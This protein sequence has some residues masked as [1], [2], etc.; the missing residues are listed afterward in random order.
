MKAFISG[1]LFFLSINFVFGQKGL[2]YASSFYGQGAFTHIKDFHRYTKRGRADGSFKNGAS[3]GMGTNYFKEDGP[4]FSFLLKYNYIEGTASG[5][6]R[7]PGGSWG[8]SSDFYISRVSAE[9]LIGG[10]A[11]ESNKVFMSGGISYGRTIF[12]HLTGETYLGTIKTYNQT[13][14]T[15]SYFGSSNVGLVFDIKC[16]IFQF[17]N[18]LSG[19]SIGAKYYLNSSIIPYKAVINEFELYLSYNF[20]KKAKPKE[21][22]PLEEPK[23]PVNWNHQHD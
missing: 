20:W 12:K 23:E 22:K 5:G 10:P 14:I 18:H 19:C 1:L 4:L 8:Y 21:P 6:D 13:E 3:F 11:V 15:N 9:F 16:F 7:S 2:P 17:R